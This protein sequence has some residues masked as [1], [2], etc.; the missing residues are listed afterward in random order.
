MLLL[1][2]LRCRRCLM[3]PA[4]ATHAHIYQTTE[5]TTEIGYGDWWKTRDNDAFMYHLFLEV[6][7]LILA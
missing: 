5:M 6:T 7:F 2:R 3:S 4:G 1:T